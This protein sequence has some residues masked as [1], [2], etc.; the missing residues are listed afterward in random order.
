MKLPKLMLM[1]NLTQSVCLSHS[2]M[3]KC[4]HNQHNNLA[5]THSVWFFHWSNSGTTQMNLSEIS[6]TV[7]LIKSLL[8]D[9]KY[10]KSSQ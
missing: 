9:Q 2:L 4:T 10:P 8:N 1:K 3:T 7:F 5:R 6:N